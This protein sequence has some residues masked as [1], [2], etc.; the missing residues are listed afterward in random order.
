MQTGG[1]GHRNQGRSREGCSHRSGG[2]TMG[3]GMVE[4]LVWAAYEEVES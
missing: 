2:G 4:G 1:G 3:E